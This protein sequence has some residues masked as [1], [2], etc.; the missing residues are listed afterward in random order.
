MSIEAVNPAV[1]LTE[2]NDSRPNY[3]RRFEPFKPLI[4]HKKRTSRRRVQIT[5]EFGFTPV[6]QEKFKKNHM[7]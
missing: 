6:N 5:D 4:L 1:G 2:L 7:F 3:M